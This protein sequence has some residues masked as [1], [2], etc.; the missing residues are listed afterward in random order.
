M[1]MHILQSYLHVTELLWI[2]EID[3]QTGS[4]FWVRKKKGIIPVNHS[5]NSKFQRQPFTT[6]IIHGDRNSLTTLSRSIFT[7]VEKF[8]INSKIF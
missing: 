8:I 5:M 2:Y 7:V 4:G 3:P 6:I 1:D